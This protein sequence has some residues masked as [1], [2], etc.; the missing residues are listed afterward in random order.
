MHAW[1]SLY[2]FVW[3]HLPAVDSC[4]ALSTRWRR[5]FAYGIILLWWCLC[6]LIKSC[7][8]LFDKVSRSLPGFQERETFFSHSL[9][10]LSPAFT[11]KI[12]GTRTLCTL[13]VLVL[14]EQGGEIRSA[15]HSYSLLPCSYIHESHYPLLLYS[16]NS[17]KFSLRSLISM[18]AC[19]LH[20]R[21]IPWS[22][23]SVYTKTYL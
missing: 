9:S 17:L 22:Y 21:L 2:E 11:I 18:A 13:P 12:Q 19:C 23:S 10:D 5:S 7:L 6:A 1:V 20:N 8:H 4:Y 14:P 16:R 15:P 3:L